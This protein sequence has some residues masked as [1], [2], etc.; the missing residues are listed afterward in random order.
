MKALDAMIEHDS[1]AGS[2]GHG[3]FSL[4]SEIPQIPPFIIII[5]IILKKGLQHMAGRER[6]TPDQSKDPNPT[7]P[8]YRKK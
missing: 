1:E 7:I 5:I 8:S 3:N 6:F 2:G 4:W